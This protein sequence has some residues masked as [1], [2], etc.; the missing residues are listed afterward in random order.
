MA[1]VECKS[2][3]KRVSS[4]RKTCR[5]CGEKNGKPFSMLRV[6][7]GVVVLL[8]FMGCVLP[9]LLRTIA[10]TASRMEGK[11]VDA[12]TEIGPGEMRISKVE[13]EQAGTV[14]VTVVKQA[15]ATV[16]A[17]FIDS[18][19]YEFLDKILKKE[20]IPIGDHHTVRS[21][22]GLSKEGLTGRFESGDVP[23]GAGTYYL[24]VEN[25]DYGK[26]NEGDGPA[27]V[28]IEVIKK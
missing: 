9:I 23:V 1:M 14:Q 25:S 27:T 20:I 15:G 16:D 5:Y 22:S 21:I 2:C 7:I 28:E 3:G 17:Y 8:I 19:T 6:T 12:T 26:T 18:E 10:N 13:M 24:V 11:V 4:K